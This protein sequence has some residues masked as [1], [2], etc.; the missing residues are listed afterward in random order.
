[1]QLKFEILLN[2][3][4]NNNNEGRFK[5]SGGRNNFDEINGGAIWSPANDFGGQSPKYNHHHQQRGFVP[6]NGRPNNNQN[7]FYGKQHRQNWNGPLERE[8]L[9][10]IRN[11]SMAKNSPRNNDGLFYRGEDVPLPAYN[12][13]Q[14]GGR[15][16]IYNSRNVGGQNGAYQPAN[17][18]GHRNNSPM[19][20]VSFLI[21]YLIF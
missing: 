7:G 18:Q 8:W 5:Y 11:P 14:N 21:V 6:R 20:L 2:E 16:I 10:G 19:K 9:K 4:S 12:R 17:E 1:M 15:K 13:H 3:K